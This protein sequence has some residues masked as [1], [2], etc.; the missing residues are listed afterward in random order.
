M[1][2]VMDHPSADAKPKPSRRKWLYR[3]LWTLLVLIASPCVY[4]YWC[5]HV[6]LTERDALIAE[7]HARGE[8]VWWHEV[9][10]KAEREQP[11]DNGA[12]LFRQA[13]ISLDKVATTA[14]PSLPQVRMGAR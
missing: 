14:T 8:P 10:A 3:T 11:E 1:M 7:I 9:V 4:W 13:L 5:R 12:E 2:P 6:A